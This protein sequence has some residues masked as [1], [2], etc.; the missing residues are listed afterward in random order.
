MS[1]IAIVLAAGKGTRM[2]SDLAKVLHSAAGRPLINWVLD[3]LDAPL[4][5]AESA[6]GD[7]P[8]VGG[9]ALLGVGVLSSLGASMMLG[10]MA[11]RLSAKNAA[12]LGAL[13]I[14]AAQAFVPDASQVQEAFPPLIRLLLVAGHDGFLFVIYP[15]APWFGVCLLG[16]A[17]GIAIQRDLSA[18]LN[19][20]LPVGVAALLAFVIVRWLGGVG[21]HHPIASDDWMALLT[22]TKYP[23]SVAFLLL[24]LGANLCFLWLLS[25]A[26]VARTRVTQLLLVYGRAPLFFY[27][28]HLYLYALIGLGIPSDTGLL[29]MYPIWGI[30]LA[31][32]YPACIR[33][34]RFKRSKSDDSIWRLF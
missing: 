13:V 5:A 29:G 20:A 11:L 32:L 33:Y 10:G 25:R 17:F 12:G 22:V 3:S 27:I 26:A 34:D 23:P 18:G 31:L 9:M 28:A 4:A 19:R 7:A 1:V 6:I 2:K 21:T 14:V 15:I 24:S 8:G 30:G 16:I